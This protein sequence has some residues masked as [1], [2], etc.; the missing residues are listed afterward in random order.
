MLHEATQH[1]AHYF[2]L[3]GIVLVALWGFLSFPQ[4]QMFQ[5]VIAISFGVSFV[6]WGIIHHHIHEELHSK[7]VLEYIATAFFG[8]TVLLFVIWGGSPFVLLPK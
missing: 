6:A 3:V 4:D 1:L 8:V 5:S 2:T 7:I